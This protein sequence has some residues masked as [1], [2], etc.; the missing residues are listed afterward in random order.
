MSELASPLPT[1]FSFLF[2]PPL[3]TDGEEHF[4]ESVSR[5]LLILVSSRQIFSLKDACTR[6]VLDF[7]ITIDPRTGVSRQLA[8]DFIASR[9]PQSSSS[10]KRVGDSK[11]FFCS[12]FTSRKRSKTGEPGSDITDFVGIGT[13]VFTSDDNF[14]VSSDSNG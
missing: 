10:S 13:T 3:I 1:G 12:D 14:S 5:K 9:R 4:M 8:L 6:F 2:I 7:C 11:L